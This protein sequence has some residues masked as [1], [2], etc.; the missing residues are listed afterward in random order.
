MKRS[1]NPLLLVPFLF[2]VPAAAQSFVPLLHTNDVVGGS[3]ALGFTPA[4]SG[5]DGHWSAVVS[6]EDA[7]G[8]YSERVVQDGQALF[9]VGDRLPSGLARMAVLYNIAGSSRNLAA[10]V[11]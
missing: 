8:N 1:L 10:C 7:T 4:L 2:S 6:F 3:P 5:E 11:R 9:D